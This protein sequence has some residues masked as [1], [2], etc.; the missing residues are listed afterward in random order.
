MRD[1]LVKQIVKDAMIDLNKDL[2]SGD[3][4]ERTYISPIKERRI[5]EKTGK[6]RVKMIEFVREKLIAKEISAEEANAIT[7]QFGKKTT[8][9]F[10]NK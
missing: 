3:V 2:E 10:W 8:K 7:N 6:H 1:A 5:S 4:I 9:L